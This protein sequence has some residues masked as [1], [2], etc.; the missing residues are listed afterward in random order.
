MSR[1][2]QLIVDRIGCTGH[3]LCAELFPEHIALDEWGYPVQSP[4][5]VRRDHL[6]HARR[7][8]AACPALALRLE[9]VRT[10]DTSDRPAN[11]H[12]TRI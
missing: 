1:A 7:A 8:V 6:A 12:R 9:A 11:R 3:G 10:R 4:E 5:P 2:H